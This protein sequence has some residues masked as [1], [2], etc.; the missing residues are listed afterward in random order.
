[1]SVGLLILAVFAPLPYW[2]IGLPWVL[3]GRRVLLAPMLGCAIAG[4]W[5]ELAL[6][7]E[8][9]MKASTAALL[10]TSAVAVA[11][12]W[13][14][15]A[16]ARAPFLEWLPWYCASVLAASVSPFPVL[17][18]WSGDWLTIYEMGQAV[19]GGTL[20]ANMLARPPLF[21]A[22]TLPLW[23]VRDGLA[24]YQL[25]AAV[26]SA[27]SLG[28]TADF[29]RFVQPRARNLWLLPLILSPFF[30]HN[31]AAAWSKLLAG[32]FVLTAACE[33]F[34]SARWASAIFF[35][36]A[37]AIHEGFIIWAPCVLLCHAD[38]Q[39]RWRTLAKA[40]ARMAAAGVAIVAPLLIWIA[41]KYGLNAKIAANPAITDAAPIPL[42]LKTLMGVLASFVA[43]GTVEVVPLWLSQAD[44]LDRGTIIKEAYWLVTSW[45]TGLAAS[46]F[47]LLWPFLLIWR[48]FHPRVWFERFAW[49]R[50][51]VSIGFPIAIVLNS[52]IAGFYSS[53]GMTQ[54]A[55]SPLV[56]GGFAFL[57]AHLFA[58][59]TDDH[60]ALRIVTWATAIVGTLPWVLVNAAVTTGLVMSEAVRERMRNG[61]EGD[62][63]RVLD[64]KLEPLGLFGYPT[65]QLLAAGA[66]CLGWVLWMRES[67]RGSASSGAPESRLGVQTPP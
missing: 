32:A 45:I 36:I 7:A 66:L 56:L 12:R 18:S 63:F 51:W 27:A 42:Y 33:A 14:D 5:A 1:M 57:A 44:P 50:S 59:D 46:F 52:A 25:M 13:R 26:A 24:P 55:L 28:A 20:P 67:N 65:V 3:G 29:L 23:L 37:V 61:S 9:P 53:Q 48:R 16:S 41:V 35:A 4:L 54:A 11:F 43:W 38:T 19:A 34:R 40:A 8:L 22:A 62:Y 17:G 15:L 49:S 6:M 30:L 21:G 39:L 58:N 10:A 60:E 31:T 64:N 2:L 47:G